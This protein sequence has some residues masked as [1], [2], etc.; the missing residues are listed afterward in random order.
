LKVHSPTGFAEKQRARA[1]P[2]AC[3]LILIATMAVGM[4]QEVR[5]AAPSATPAP[6]ELFGIHPVQEGRTTLP[7]G[8]FNFALVPGQRIS[9]GI[10]VVNFSSHALRFHVYGADLLTAIGGGL[11]PAQPTATKREVGA[12]I[13][14]SAPVLTIAAHSQTTDDFALTV[15]AAAAPGQHLGAVV[16]AADI[17]VTAQGNPIEARAALIAV[18]TVPGAAHPSARLT[19]LFGSG[20]GPRQFGFRITASNTGNVLLTY[21]GSVMIDD[22][23]GRPIAKLPLTPTNAYIVPGALLPLAATWKEPAQ[24]AAAY[25]AQA[26]VTVLANGVPVGTLTSQSLPV[27]FPSAVPLW[28]LAGLA[29]VILVLIALAAWATRRL[30]RGQRPK[31]VRRELGTARVG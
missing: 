27:L 15:P 10:V 8:H 29:L 4:A 24:P 6:S 12:W 19:T 18:V 7:G 14:V 26:T 9:D 16:A 22:A 28:L 30:V 5:A 2:A 17:G 3:S 23:N 25:R 21:A 1:M 31:H 11:A 20:T 13:A